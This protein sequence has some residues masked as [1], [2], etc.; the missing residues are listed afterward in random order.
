[1]DAELN[2]ARD[3]LKGATLRNTRCEEIIREMREKLSNKL[4]DCDQQ[5]RIIEQCRIEM[6]QLQ[7]AQ[8]Q[9][10]QKLFVA[11][12]SNTNYEDQISNLRRDIDGKQQ[13]IERLER[14]L[15]EMKE[16]MS[17]LTLEKECQ[18]QKVRSFYFC[19]HNAFIPRN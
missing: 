14:R 17:S 12:E 6:K 1:M 13:E 19:G 11:E 4:K 5:N 3:Q 7:D 15:D 9:T 18:Q 16:D 10:N 8:E 2:S